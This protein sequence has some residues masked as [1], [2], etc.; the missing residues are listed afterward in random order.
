M[1]SE[2]LSLQAA[3]GQDFVDGGERIFAALGDIGGKLIQRR[4]SASGV[5]DALY[6]ARLEKFEQMA[7]PVFGVFFGAFAAGFEVGAEFGDG[8]GEIVD[9]FVFGGDGSKDGRMPAV[10]GHYQRKHGLELLFEAVGAFAIGFVEDED[11]G[12]F[13]QAGF[14][15]LNI[16][17]QAGYENDDY[18]IG[19]TNDVDFV[20]ADADG[21]DE[22]LMF[23]R[24]VKEQ[25]DFGR[26]AGE[27]AKES[28]R[29][30]RTDEDASVAGV[31]LHT[32]TIAENCAARVGA[33]RVHGDNSY[34]LVLFAMLRRDAIDQSA[35]SRAGRASDA[36]EI[37]C[38]SLREKNF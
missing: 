1:D 38:A 37:G 5:Q 22:D 15:V 14:H 8:G 9:A 13:H 25:R 4:F 17:A 29:G 6:E 28:A 35:L 31:A 33:G 18:T 24:G 34:A 11:V 10:S 16:V 23:A 19:E 36:G 12:D 7:A 3:F 32:D 30:H 26:G 2:F 21:F 27:A 20:L